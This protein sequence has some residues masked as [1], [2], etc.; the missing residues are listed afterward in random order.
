[1]GFGGCWFGVVAIGA[2]RGSGR[3]CREDG[4]EVSGA[5]WC[6]SAAGRQDMAVVVTVGGELVVAE[7]GGWNAPDRGDVFRVELS[8]LEVVCSAAALQCAVCS[9]SFGNQ[10]WPNLHA[11]GAPAWLPG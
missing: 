2:V 11:S 9:K 3:W 5:Q 8:L 1:M 7:V 10:R 6:V 4:E